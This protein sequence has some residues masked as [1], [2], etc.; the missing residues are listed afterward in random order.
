MAC[1][2][3]L[4]SALEDDLDTVDCFL[5]FQETS[6]EP[7]KKQNPEMDLLVSRQEPQSESVKPFSLQSLL[8]GKNRPSAGETLMYPRTRRTA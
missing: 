7:R 6:E 8:A 4:Y 2:K 3:A 5:L 1:A